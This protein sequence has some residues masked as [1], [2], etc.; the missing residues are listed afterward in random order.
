[1]V[2]MIRV[3]RPGGRR[4]LAVE[5]ADRMI[6]VDDD[7]RR[8]LAEIPCTTTKSIAR[9][10]VH[11]PGTPTRRPLAERVTHQPERIPSP[12]R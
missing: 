3:L 2:E 5:P 10:K 1:V 9:F 12:S 11:Q 7:T 6:C 8:V 4:I